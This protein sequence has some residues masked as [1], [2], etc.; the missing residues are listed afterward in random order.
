MSN[1]RSDVHI[2]CYDVNHLKKKGIS[3][4]QKNRMF[5]EI[6]VNHLKKKGISNIVEGYV[7]AHGDVNHLKTKATFNYCC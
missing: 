5:D 2:Y 3:N 6:D 1:G 7:L 4:Q